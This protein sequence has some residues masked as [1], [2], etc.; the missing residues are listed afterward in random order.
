M[1]SSND[2]G[3]KLTFSFQIDNCVEENYYQITICDDKENFET[4]KILCENGG[5]S[6]SF[7][8][9]LEYIF[10]FEKRQKMTLIIFKQDMYNKDKKNIGTAK[11]IY[12]ADIVTIKDGIYETNLN[13]DLNTEKIQIKV[14][15]SKE[16]KDKRYLFDYLKSGIKLSC[17]I[18]FDF[19]QKNKSKIKDDNL[20]ILKNIFQY[21]EG[22]TPDHLY[23]A[24]GFG[25]K[26]KG[27]KILAFDIDKSK[28]NSDKLIEKYKTSLESNNIIP[29]KNIALSPIIKKITSDIYQTYE[30][31]KYYV[32]FLLLSK[33][34]DKKDKKNLIHQII[35]SS[36]LPLSIFIIGIGNHD[37]TEAKSTLKKISKYSSE[38]MAKVRDNITFIIN[39]SAITA[40]KTIS[41]CLKEL[42]KQMIEF[43]I[44]NK[45]FP[46]NND[47]NDI[48]ESINL[49]ASIQDKFENK[50]IT[51]ESSNSNNEN[52][53]QTYN[54]SPI[55]N[56][57]SETSNQNKI[58]SYNPDIN[59]NNDN[60]KNKDSINIG[61]TL[62]SNNANDNVKGSN[63]SNT[64]S[65]QIKTSDFYE[66]NVINPYAI[67]KKVEKSGSSSSTFNSKNSGQ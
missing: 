34:I 36:Y 47:N 12:L 22:Y 40:N 44:Y 51:Y 56:N 62:N 11:F 13:E 35:A 16:Y 63:N 7:K 5:E 45:Y 4:E 59:I 39:N 31:D 28:L 57:K 65:Y 50:E 8:K 25:A 46:E 15:K 55:E 30:P 24:S 37:F 20:N 66:T 9:K 18:S 17:F 26:I 6:L 23:Y 1:E 67:K 58:N 60:D 14:Q 42:S 53:F 29:D 52:Q 32:L 21:I 54:S 61:N 2:S 38:G 27:N 19:S 48:K 64:D 43:Y 41:F 3:E 10:F 49:Y 33:D